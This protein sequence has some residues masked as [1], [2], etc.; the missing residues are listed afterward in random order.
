MGARKRS[1]ML[2]AN[3]RVSGYSFSLLWSSVN[4]R[5]A[6]SRWAGEMSVSCNKQQ[7][8][9]EPRPAGLGGR[10]CWPLKHL[11]SWSQHIMLYF[12]VIIKILFLWWDY[13]INCQY[14]AVTEAEGFSWL[15]KKCFVISTKHV[16]Q[17]RYI[18]FYDYERTKLF[19]NNFFS[20]L[21][22]RE[23]VWKQINKKKI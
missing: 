11:F 12:P 21:G 23:Q 16:C 5:T 18:W 8:Y 4:Q 19:L 17:E 6:S 7:Q 13:G 14:V 20:N 1:R 10:L 2:T 3:T 22:L 9:Q 15:R